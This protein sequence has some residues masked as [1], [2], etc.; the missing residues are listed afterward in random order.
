MIWPVIEPD[1]IRS[2][3]A[4]GVVRRPCFGSQ[5]RQPGGCGALVFN[6]TG[7]TLV[8]A[9][10]GE[11]TSPLGLV[12]FASQ[13]ADLSD[14]DDAAGTG[15]LIKPV[16]GNNVRGLVLRCEPEEQQRDEAPGLSLTW[17]CPCPV[18]KTADPE[19]PGWCERSMN[20]WLGLA[21]G[22]E[23]LARDEAAFWLRPGII[24]TFAWGEDG[25]ASTIHGHY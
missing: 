7:T 22:I 15:S 23:A 25:Q 18:F 24:T 16:L 10:E 21:E 9:N 14:R 19:A 12:D 5:F 1:E 6:S 17:P 13:L 20:R 4:V 11:P 3:P 2:M 8:V